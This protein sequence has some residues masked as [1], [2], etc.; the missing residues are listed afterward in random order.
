MIVVEFNQT[1]TTSNLPDADIAISGVYMVISQTASGS[2]K[3]R[4]IESHDRLMMITKG[5]LKAT[6]MGKTEIVKTNDILYVPKNTIYQSQSNSAALEHICILYD[7]IDLPTNNLNINFF[8]TPGSHNKYIKLFESCQQEYWSKSFGYKLKTKSLL[9]DILRHLHIEQYVPKNM[10]KYYHGIKVAIEYINDNYST[11][12]ISIEHLAKMCNITTTHFSRTFKA[13][14][15]TTPV[16]YIN[17]LRLEKACALLTH[18]NLSIGEISDQCGFADSS[19][20]SK[21]FKSA[22]GQSPA[23]YRNSK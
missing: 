16:K 12:Q 19:Y 20:F 17:N 14:Y 9:Y 8:Y 15:S 1:T 7:S 13:M 6:I 2:W 18:T 21:T 23:N 11:E 22:Y 4:S 3:H 10:S 5:S